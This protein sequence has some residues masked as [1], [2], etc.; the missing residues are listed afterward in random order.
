MNK[1]LIAAIVPF[2][3]ASAYA[4]VNCKVIGKVAGGYPAQRAVIGYEDEKK[5]KT[6]TVKINEG[7]FEFTSSAA[8]P[9][10]AQVT[11]L[12]PPPP[13]VT[14]RRSG[15]TEEDEGG[16]KNIALFYLED[17]IRVNFDTAGMATV[18]GGGKEQQAYV[19]FIANG[20]EEAKKTDPL[21]FDKIVGAF[22]KNNPDAYI[23][24]D[25][26]EM[27]AGVIQPA[28]F[29]PMWMSLSDRLRNTDKA[30]EWK[31]RLE[32]A[33]KFDVGSKSIDFTLTSVKGTPV[34]LSSFRG[35]YVLLDFW[36]SWCA[37]CRAGHPELINIY[38]KYKGNKFE[39]LAVSLDNKKEA[40]LKAIKEDKLPWMQASD[41]KGASGK[42]AKM[43]NI[44]QI[45]QN[46]LIDPDGVIVGRN[47]TG[48]PLD[49]KLSELI[50]G[51]VVAQ[52][53]ARKKY[54][55]DD[56]ML[57]EKVE[58]QEKY[59]NEMMQ[60]QPA[61][62]VNPAA[63]NDYR[64]ELAFAWLTKGNV[65][66]YKHYKATNPKFTPRQFLYLTSA[67]EKLF[68]EKKDYAAVA[69][70][71][72]ELLDNL[73]KHTLTD[74]V[75][76][77]PVLMELNAA[78]NAKLGNIH[79]AKKMI[80]KSSAA[81]GSD[82]RE[83]KY[84]K[85]MKSN[86]LNRYAIVMS[87]AG[88]YQTAYDTLSKAFKAAESNPAMVA[89]F[90]DV[91]Q[92][93]KGS[94][95]GFEEYL[96][97]LKNEAYQEYYREVE[98]MYIA[99]PQKTLEGTMPD[100]EGGPKPVTTFR[101]KTPVKDITLQKL[102]G[103]SVHLGDYTGKILAIDFWTTLCTP[104]VAAFSGFE[105]VV[106][107]YNK[108]EFQLF[109][110]NLFETSAT[111]KA[112]VAQKGITLNVLQDEENTAYDVQGTPTKIIFDPMGNIRFYSSGYAGSTD[113]EYYKLKAMV[114]ITKARASGAVTALSK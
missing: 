65:E 15:D 111:V 58:D 12:V 6:D 73:E 21:P 4:Q 3:A 102:D 7:Q 69:L 8:R 90:R 34:S 30:K 71:S 68:D 97:S 103:K 112:Y 64:G 47:L 41:L 94:D 49:E 56:F 77:T 96:A 95:K 81:E 106:A 57:I 48:K 44:A 113:R 10:L 91:Y 52:Q 110:I 89:T 1:L 99:L 33:K 37:P 60:Q 5:Y 53:P 35:R 67:L 17:T 18:T 38:N 55:F 14:K 88:Q 43:Y 19:A 108:D 26:M 39:I 100:P 29:E 101:A 98:K 75:G 50:S 9:A 78:A 83:I 74:G 63:T 109:V 46:L 62:K 107:D 85:D 86:Y 2:M 92:K 114:E 32:E 93:L 54:K 105:H 20:Q 80:A 104:C 59:Y 31:V 45:P 16:A 70:I 84:F 22:I 42:V 23:S 40:W 76:R 87:A 25:I 66:R 61:G 36:A 82:N 13:G 72:G 28:T 79:V 24:L 51:A 11:L 27:F